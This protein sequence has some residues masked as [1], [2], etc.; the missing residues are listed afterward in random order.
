MAACIV[1]VLPVVPACL[2]GSSLA[3]EKE[4]FYV[5]SI[6]DD[7]AA[8]KLPCFTSLWPQGRAQKNRR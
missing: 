3:K 7:E 8:L 6:L 1:F 4:N 2:A 5:C